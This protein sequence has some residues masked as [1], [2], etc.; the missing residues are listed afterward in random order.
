MDKLREAFA[1]FVILC[2]KYELSINATKTKWMRFAKGGRIGNCGSLFMAGEQIERV[3]S[4]TYLGV[5]VTPSLSSFDSHLRVR[6]AKATA[7]SYAIAKPYNLSLKCALKLYGLKVEPILCYGAEVVWDKLTAP[8]L[9]IYDTVK[10]NFL[11]RVLGLAK[12]TRNRLVF[13]MCTTT[14]GAESVRIRLDLPATEAFR[15]YQDELFG[16]LSGIDDAFYGDPMEWVSKHMGP[17]ATERHV[18][19]RLAAHGY[20]AVICQREDF[21]YADSECVCE[22]CGDHCS[23]YHLLTCPERCLSVQQYARGATG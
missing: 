8:Q 16:R 15:I 10:A 17:L 6:A 20:H 22:L 18:Y 23:Q 7:A 1:F 12:G 5:V 13:L 2:S 9:R 11:K 14:T 19:A 3:T 4:F 21:H